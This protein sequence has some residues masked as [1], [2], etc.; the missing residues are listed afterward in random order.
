MAVVLEGKVTLNR[1]QREALRAEIRI[2]AGD[3][4]DVNLWLD[5][6]HLDRASVV[7]RIALLQQ[8]VAAL[9]AIGWAE[10]EDAPDDLEVVVDR[11]LALWAHGQFQALS[12]S[13]SE[14]TP[15]DMDGALTTLR[16][17]HLIADTD[18]AGEKR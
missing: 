18:W 11:Q 1:A 13:L 14:S 12:R 8:L 4:G 16:A 9:D 15:Y 3:C 10:P 6:P 5:Q 2:A 7:A 17:L